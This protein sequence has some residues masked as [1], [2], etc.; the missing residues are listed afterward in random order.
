MSKNRQQ[1]TNMPDGYT[2]MFRVL[3]DGLL[4]PIQDEAVDRVMLTGLVSLDDLTALGIDVQKLVQRGSLEHIGIR[5]LETYES[6]IPGGGGGKL[7]R[8]TPQRVERLPF[9]GGTTSPER[10]EE[11]LGRVYSPFDSG[12]PGGQASLPTYGHPTGSNDSVR[13]DVSGSKSQPGKRPAKRNASR[14]KGSAS[15]NE[16]PPGEINAEGE[17]SRSVAA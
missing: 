12:P 1:D 13:E 4:A 15:H 2:H 17:K 11:G 3:S 5:S 6:Q 9:E 7:T 14:A 8:D 16:L 10:R